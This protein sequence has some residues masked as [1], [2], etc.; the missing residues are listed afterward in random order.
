MKADQD[1]VELTFCSANVSP[2]RALPDAL[3]EELYPQYD[4]TNPD[5]DPDRANATP[6]Q[7]K[8][9]REKRTPSP[10]PLKSTNGP[11]LPKL[12]RRSRS[13]T[14][15]KDEQEEKTFLESLADVIRAP[16]SLFYKDAK[17]SPKMK[18]V[19]DDDI[20]SCSIATPKSTR[21][22]PRKSV[23]FQPGISFMEPEQRSSPID[24]PNPAPSL[25]PFQLAF[26]PLAHGFIS[27][28]QGAILTA[29][30]PETRILKSSPELH[31]ALNLGETRD[32][33]GD[34]ETKSQ[35]QGSLADT[36]VPQGKDSSIEDPFADPN[37][38]IKPGRTQE[39]LTEYDEHFQSKKVTTVTPANVA[40][41][42]TFV[43][44][45][46]KVQDLAQVQTTTV[47]DS[48]NTNSHTGASTDTEPGEH[49]ATPSVHSGREPGISEFIPWSGGAPSSASSTFQ[50]CA[51]SERSG[52]L[53]SPVLKSMSGSRVSDA[54]LER[55]DADH[56]LSDEPTSQEQVYQHLGGIFGTRKW[57]QTPT[58]EDIRQR[59]KAHLARKY[60]QPKQNIESPAMKTIPQDSPRNA[61][62][63]AA[64]ST[65]ATNQSNSHSLGLDELDLIANL[66]EREEE[67]PGNDARGMETPSPQKVRAPMV[68]RTITDRILEPPFSQK[69]KPTLPMDG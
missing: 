34:F 32:Y 42:R 29:R 30:P 57:I 38:H 1:V 14:S 18:D 5:H 8:S 47:G 22:S 31:H 61:S 58:H 15:L 63:N 67:S 69:S 27:E 51:S 20:T 54:P 55:Y 36:P 43:S 45:D 24:I 44:N 16:T 6:T 2:V 7:Q 12:I 50:N 19:A 17:Q 60:P 4:S 46:E 13:Q 48:S 28:L 41:D 62:C 11:R 64:I 39:M 53:K 9:L 59:F 3:E 25:P 37:N 21:W 10:H 56:E 52:L 49:V 68:S 40:I 26:T 35:K 65:F 66:N 33:F 23:T